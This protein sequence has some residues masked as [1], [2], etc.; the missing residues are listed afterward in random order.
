MKNS[1]KKLTLA[2]YKKVFVAN[3]LEHLMLNYQINKNEL[4]A[5]QK[6]FTNSLNEDTDHVLHYSSEYWAHFIAEAAEL[7]KKSVL[8]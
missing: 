3:V 4:S 6:K 5:I 8:V 1:K 2:E 7:K